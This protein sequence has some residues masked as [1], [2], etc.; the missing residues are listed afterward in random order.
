MNRRVYRT[1]AGREA[2]ETLYR[3]VLAGYSSHGFDQLFIP[4][5]A[6]QTHVLRFGKKTNPPLVMIHG[7]ASNS[8]VWLGN[9][10][11]FIDRFCVYC[12]DIPGEP[13]LSEPVR[14]TL[15]SDRPYVWL[16]SLLN[17]LDIG[18]AAFVTMSLGSWYT[19]NFSVRSPS[20]VRALSM[21]TSS[22]IVPAKKSFIFKAVFF[23]MLGKPGQK[24]LNKAIYH[25]TEVPPEVLAY[26]AI[27]SKHFIPVTEAV[28]VFRDA[29]L[30]RITAP[31]QFFGG[32]HDVLIDAV[33]TGKR[34]KKLLPHAEINILE[35]TGHVIMDQ[36]PGIKDFL[37]S[38]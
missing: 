27:V 35:D 1:E 13:G 14:H 7:T 18:K 3:N 19:L 25:K 26:Q 30:K 16:R 36:F 9:I 11:D 29:Q 34:L 21:I 15:K 5:E 24:M 38:G 28:P 10:P 6:G 23:M 12:V 2:V 32:D 20:R 31:I 8:A 22:G 37:V 4:T 33:K 17:G